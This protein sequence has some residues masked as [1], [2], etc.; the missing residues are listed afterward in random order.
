[1]EIL[2]VIVIILL[3]IN[4]YFTLN[5][6]RNRVQKGGTANIGNS[7]L[8]IQQGV[9]DIDKS[10][11]KLEKAFRDEISRNREESRKGEKEARIELSIQVQRLSEA[12]LGRMSEI[13][14]FQKNQLDTYSN[15]IEK[16]LKSFENQFS[17]S[18]NEFNNLQKEKFNDLSQK[19]GELLKSTEDKLE[20]MR[21]TVDE[22]LQSTLEKRL[23]ES[24]KLVSERLE[25]VHKGLGE[26][27][28]LAMGVGDLKKVLSNV[29]T[30]GTLGEIQLGRIL[31]QILT[32]DQYDINVVTK[33]ESRDNVEFA[34]RLPGKDKAS[35]VVY[36]PVDSKFPLDVYHNLVDAYDTGDQSLIEEGYKKLEAAIKKSAKDIRD[37][38]ID[39]PYT[40]DFAIMFLPIEG[41]YAE[42]VK[43]TNLVEI[44]QREYKINIT[45][46]TTLAALLNSLQMGFR[47]LAIEKR[48]SEVWNV[49]GAVK[50]EFGKFEEVLKATQKKLNQASTD[51]D[52]LVGTR[53]KQINKKLMSVESLTND[54]S[55]KY[56]DVFPI[57]E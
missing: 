51:L 21:E 46:P 15:T 42:V 34:I 45:G 53:T 26:M 39:P 28:T 31:D 38:Y 7:I 29:K 6:S 5:N 49:L 17:K 55:E 8:Q 50:T 22:K 54:A 2:L 3:I 44:L 27:Q 52:K 30:R 33:K 19:Q 32:K 14:N 25:V 18:V 43:R 40:T 11:D 12:I 1:M 48:S 10:V 56:I 57:E 20:K 36:L 35:D 16:S 24:F 47:T 23:G 13:A 4:I 37:K 9:G 41:L